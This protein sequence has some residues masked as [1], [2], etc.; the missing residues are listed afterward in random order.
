MGINDIIGKRP[1]SRQN[2]VP[3]GRAEPKITKI[4]IFGW[5]WVEIFE[6][7]KE[8]FQKKTSKTKGISINV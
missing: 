1:Q 2:E 5:I 3:R 8:I 6:I 7:K 4:T